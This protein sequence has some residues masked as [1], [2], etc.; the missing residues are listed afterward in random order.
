MHTHRGRRRDGNT[1]TCREIPR[2]REMVAQTHKLKRGREEETNR[3]I[4]GETNRG[5]EGETNRMIDRV[6][7]YV[8]V[9]ECMCV[10]V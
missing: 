7:V 1:H 9:C 5:R 6:C 3:G 10:C 2:D 4:E 8:S